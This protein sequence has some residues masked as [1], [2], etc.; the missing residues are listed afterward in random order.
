MTWILANMELPKVLE[1]IFII[2]AVILT[3]VGMV[4]FLYATSFMSDQEKE[5]LILMFQQW[6]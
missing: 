1:T 3:I 6:E 4:A 5:Q 2:I